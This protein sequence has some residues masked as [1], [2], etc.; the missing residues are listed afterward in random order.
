[1]RSVTIKDGGFDH[2]SRV[3]ESN[4]AEVGPF[5][6]GIIVADANKPTSFAAESVVQREAGTTSVAE[7]REVSGTSTVSYGNVI[8]PLILGEFGARESVR[9]G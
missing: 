9:Y 4:A 1:M 3:G 7:V 8:E 2:D 5:I 6:A